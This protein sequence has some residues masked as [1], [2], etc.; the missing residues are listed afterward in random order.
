MDDG[1]LGSHLVFNRCPAVSF[2]GVDRVTTPMITPLQNN[3]F[4]GRIGEY[5]IRMVENITD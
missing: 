4:I 1:A 3:A 2:W 5:R